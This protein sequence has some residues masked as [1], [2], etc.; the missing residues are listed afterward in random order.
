MLLA[1]M[2][3][4]LV[5]Y[6]AF[7][8]AF[9]TGALFL[10]QERQLKHKHMGML[11]HRLPPLETLDQWNLHAIGW[12]FGLLTVGLAIGMAVEHRLLGRWWSWDP[13]ELLTV[14]LWVTYLAL[15]WLRL[16]ATLRGRKIAFLS[17]LGFGLMIFTF[18]GVSRW[19]PSWHTTAFHHLS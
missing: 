6:V 3:C 10:I 16:G 8:V 15:W 17:I 12:G 19:W 5:S 7:L 4:T 9:V 1:H 11:F 13:K 18:I 2:T 14:V